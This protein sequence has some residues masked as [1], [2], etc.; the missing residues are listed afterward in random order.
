[1]DYDCRN[2]VV[3]A[4]HVEY[5][6]IHIMDKAL[7]SS[8]GFITV[9]PGAFSAYRWKSIDGPP[10]WDDYFRGF[11]E[12]HEI[13]CFHSN[14]YLAEDRVLCLSLVS[15]PGENNVLRYVK[16]ATA[17]TDVPDNLQ[18]LL[19]QRRRW[20]NGSWHALIDAMNMFSRVNKTTH[21]CCTKCGIYFEMFY[22][23]LN[24]VCAWLMVG[25]L[26]LT[27]AIMARAVFGENDDD[28]EGNGV[29]T[30]SNFVII[31][32]LVLL[33]VTFIVVIGVIPSK[34]RR[35]YYILMV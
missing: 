15:K 24:I 17:T 5:K 18:A 35:T 32:Y 19:A 9:L 20:I 1:M 4:Q 3:A 2:L 21:G 11:K 7:E 10:L 8:I 14:I 30:W 27:F 16:N 22:F 34:T 31:L 12:P 23:F 25:T 26:F 33:I 29:W 6:F 13:D 28:D